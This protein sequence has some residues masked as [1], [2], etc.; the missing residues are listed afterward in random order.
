MCACAIVEDDV[1]EQTN[2]CHRC[3]SLRKKTQKILGPR[4]MEPDSVMDGDDWRVST[5]KP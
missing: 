1:L 4:G 5:I 3:T 2:T